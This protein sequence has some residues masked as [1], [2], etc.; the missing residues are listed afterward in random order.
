MKTIFITILL[1]SHLVVSITNIAFAKNYDL[2]TVSVK[3]YT[4]KIH[5]T[6]KLA[7]KHTSNLSFKSSG[8][9]TK[10]KVD[11]GNYFTKNQLLAQ[12]DS[13][14]LVENRNMKYAQLLRAK[15]EFTRLA[16]LRAH[17][18]SSQQ[19]LDNAKT[20]VET[21]RA[22][23]KIAYYQLEKTQIIAPFNGIV[24]EKYTELGELQSPGRN[25]LRVAALKNNW[26]I[27]V[28]LTDNEV[29]QVR[30]KQKVHI[31][32][33]DN[34][35]IIG[36]ISK[37]PALA[38]SQ[39]NLF[40]VEILIPNLVQKSGIISG[41]LADITIDFTSAT[42][43]YRLPISALV[44]VDDNGKAI[45]VTEQL[46]TKKLIRQHYDIYKLDNRYVYVL[47]NNRHHPIR[48]VTQGWQN[49]SLSK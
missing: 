10:L 34:D 39:S 6:G 5:R 8:Y 36:I 49:L 11:E 16:K 46:N 32:L 15:R 27:K 21:T 18:L 35:N 1:L 2:V 45:I 17:K 31:R 3:P 37:I 33:A 20:L 4:D 13:T 9:L 7:F 28:S 41:Q 12:L 44:A 24:L 43:V 25:V 42:F 23:Y 40:P 30:L 48:I 26:I 19:Q 47:A 22:A 29:T 38:N 14:E